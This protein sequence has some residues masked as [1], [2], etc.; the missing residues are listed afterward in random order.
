LITDK[1]LKCLCRIALEAG[2]EIM[3]VYTHGGVVYEKEDKSPLTEADLR[4]DRVIADGLIKHF[5]QWWI[6]SEET[7]EATKKIEPLTM[8]ADVGNQVGDTF[9]LVDP[10]DGTKE[11]VNRNGEFTVNIALIHAGQAIAGVVYAPAMDELFYGAHG[12]GAYKKDAK[13]ERPIQTS[14]PSEDAPLRVIGSRSHGADKLEQWLRGLSRRFEF[15]AAGSSL[16]FCRIAEGLADVYPRFG[17][18]S[19][20]D[21][22]AAQAVLESAGGAVRDLSGLPLSYGLNKSILNPEFMAVACGE[23]EF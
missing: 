22:A 17:P 5:P 23:V 12:I 3:D 2:K 15:V 19:Q 20:W 13:G 11:F 18:T 7:Y 4:A 21:T 1:D 6:V 9:F 8:A 16:K 14:H 10:L